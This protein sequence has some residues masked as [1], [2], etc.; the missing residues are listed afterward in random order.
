MSLCV[1]LESD[2]INKSSE[3]RRYTCAHSLI[4]NLSSSRACV[5]EG[6]APQ[7]VLVAEAPSALEA[8]VR[9]EVAQSNVVVAGHPGGESGRAMFAGKYLKAQEFC[10]ISLCDVINFFLTPQP[11][12][13]ETALLASD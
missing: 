11:S 1:A 6:V 12:T 9:P 10:L 13:E 7:F 3:S 2:W 5:G 4:I 8:L